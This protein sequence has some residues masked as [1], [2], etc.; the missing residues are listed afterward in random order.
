M[1]TEEGSTRQGTRGI[2]L[3]LPFHSSSNCNLLEQQQLLAKLSSSR[4]GDS[5]KFRQVTIALC[6]VD[7]LLDDDSGGDSARKLPP[8]SGR[9]KPP[10]APN[11]DNSMKSVWL[12]WSIDNKY[13]FE[14]VQLTAEDYKGF[15]GQLLSKSITDFI[16]IIFPLFF[17]L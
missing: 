7:R 1:V 9:D 13:K 16:I 12:K 14:R 15:S 6:A 4:V 3:L 5:E 8:A 11:R 10:A 2:L 17:P